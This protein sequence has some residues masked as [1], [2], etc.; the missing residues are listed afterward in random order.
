MELL[1]I[2]CYI[3]VIEGLRFGVSDLRKISRIKKNQSLRGVE[4]NMEIGDYG[5]FIGIVL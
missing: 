3:G 5:A 1:L 2:D 4:K